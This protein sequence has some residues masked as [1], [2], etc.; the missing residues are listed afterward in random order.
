MGESALIDK[1]SGRIFWEGGSTSTIHASIAPFLGDLGLR[2]LKGTA[3]SVL[4]LF[5]ALS[6][7]ATYIRERITGWE[8]TGCPMIVL[9]TL[10]KLTIVKIPK[11]NNWLLMTTI[12]CYLLEASTCNTRRYLTNAISSPDGV[13][14]YIERL[15]NENPIVTWKVRCFHYERRW[16]AF[17]VAPQLLFRNPD[18]S[19]DADGNGDR[20]LGVTPSGLLTKKVVTH[21]AEATYTF[22]QCHDNTIAGVWKRAELSNSIL[23]P[24][25][26]ISLRK[27]LV[28]PNQKARLDYFQQQ[29]TFV[30]AQGQADEFAEFSTNIQ[31]KG[32]KP[33]LL[34]VRSIDGIPSAKLFR[35]S[36]FW[37]FTCLGMSVPFRIWFAR[38]CDMLRV[39][40]AKETSPDK[41]SSTTPKS[42]SGWFKWNTAVDAT[43]DE[44]PPSETFRRMMQELSLYGT[45]DKDTNE[46]VEV[47]TA[48]S[49]LAAAAAT[50]ETT[51]PSTLTS[52]EAGEGGGGEGWNNSTICFIEKDVSG[53]L[54]ETMS[55]V[56]MTENQDVATNV[57]T[58]PTVD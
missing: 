12:L 48:A 49:A 58:V 20:T 29:A 54:N 45:D 14:E 1:E 4:L 32:F 17:L 47:I 22:N 56:P 3:L 5:A 34:A 28:L 27:L 30:T 37:I 15:R 51:L 19:G 53:V 40:V 8:P 55:S 24:F 10:I 9:L 23:A 13:E 50:N 11:F 7:L 2:H 46:I 39:T 33:R 25:T 57:T 18:M 38:H 41:V 36:L 35:H 43:S 52:L 6:F 42:N 16:L 31:V 26:K 44:M 21:H